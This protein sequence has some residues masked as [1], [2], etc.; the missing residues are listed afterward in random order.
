MEYFWECF[1]IALALATAM[2]VYSFRPPRMDEHGEVID[3]V[4]RVAKAIY[5]SWENF[6]VASDRSWE[7]YCEKL[8]GGADIFRRHARRAIAAADEGE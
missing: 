8:P 3:R 4:E 2:L 7:T 5:E 6:P 1:V